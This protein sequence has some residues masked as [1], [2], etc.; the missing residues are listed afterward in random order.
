MVIK[1]A[2]IGLLM[3]IGIPIGWTWGYW[4]GYEQGY[5]NGYN[6]IGVFNKINNAYSNGFLEGQKSPEQ[7]EKE[8]REKMEKARKQRESI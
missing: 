7:R 8:E 3:V 6:S 2:F 4:E 5:Y 1:V